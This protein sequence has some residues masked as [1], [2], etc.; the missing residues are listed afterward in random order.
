VQLDAGHSVF[1]DA[2]APYVAVLASVL[3]RYE[4]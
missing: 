2:P 1:R 3:S 4:R